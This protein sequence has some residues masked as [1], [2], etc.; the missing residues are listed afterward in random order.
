MWWL[1][2]KA[3]SYKGRVSQRRILSAW[4]MRNGEKFTYGQYSIHSLGIHSANTN[5]ISL[6]HTANYC[7][8][9]KVLCL[10]EL[11]FPVFPLFN[12]SHILV[13]QA[14]CV[15]VCAYER[16]RETERESIS[17]CYIFGFPSE[18]AG[19][20]RLKTPHL[21]HLSGLSLHPYSS[22]TIVWFISDSVIYLGWVRAEV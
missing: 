13:V 21:N 20:P 14:S 1:L 17:V 16:D 9:S 5:W 19:G 6:A 4:A 2:I 22:L 10:G 15:C 7:K 12:S 8:L 3:Y 18:P 11:H